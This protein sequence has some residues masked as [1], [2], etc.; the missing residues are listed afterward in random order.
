MIRRV[1]VAWLFGCTTA[2]AADAPVQPRPAD[3]AWQLPLAVSGNNG[4]VQFR[5]PVE[6]YARAQHPQMA[7]LRVFDPA[8]QPVPFALHRPQPAAVPAIREQVVEQFPVHAGAAD[9]DGAIAL[10]VR[11]SRDGSLLAI[12]ARSEPRSA[13]A[14]LTALIVDLGAPHDGET[15]EQLQFVLPE[16]STDYR[17]VLRLEQSDD[18]KLW[19]ALAQS[20]LDWIAAASGDARL[21]N[22]RIALT[23]ATGRYLRIAWRDGTPIEF[24]RIVARWRSATAMTDTRLQVVLDPQPG[25]IYPTGPAIAATQLGLEL[26][27][28]NTVLPVGI[29]TYRAQPRLQPAWRFDADVDAT[30]HRLLRNGVERRSGLIMTGPIAH[31][32]WVVRSQRANEAAPKLV[33]RWQPDNARGSGPFT[34]AFGAAPEQV[35]TWTSGATTLALVAPGYAARELAELEYANAGDIRASAIERDAMPPAESAGSLIDRRTA[36]LWGVLALGVLVLAGMS[37]RLFKQMGADKGEAG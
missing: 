2:L 5:L 22:D 1:V 21:V 31:A 28:E 26:A 24:G 20:S 9:A 8:G 33:L 12:E 30:F 4:V 23:G 10:N 14:P 19:D 36:L 7:D 29:G 35:R 11:A 13:A 37:W 32:E 18:L 6:V 27:Q 15:L 17:A 16:G 25:R 34:L 3:F